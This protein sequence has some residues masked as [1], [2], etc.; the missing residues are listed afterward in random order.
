[1][2]HDYQ[3]PLPETTVNNELKILRESIRHISRVTVY[4]GYMV[5]KVPYGTAF[6]TVEKYINPRIKEL[7]LNLVAEATFLTA[8][9]S[10][11]IKEKI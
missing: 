5:Y 6:G 2:F 3:I 10:F 7:G 1:M 8:N 11:L 4:D 9:D